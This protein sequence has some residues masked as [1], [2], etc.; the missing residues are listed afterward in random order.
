[1]IYQVDGWT[2][3]LDHG[4]R[5]VIAIIIMKH[6]FRIFPYDSCDLPAMP[7]EVVGIKQ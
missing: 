3:Q 4:T 7:Y 6:G 5:E 1:M 2:K